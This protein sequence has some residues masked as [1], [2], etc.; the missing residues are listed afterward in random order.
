MRKD[1][2]IIQFLQFDECSIARTKN[3][4]NLVHTHTHTEREGGRIPVKIRYSQKLPGREIKQS[5]SLA[6]GNSERAPLFLFCLFLFSSSILQA[7]PSNHSLGTWPKMVS[8]PDITTTLFQYPPLLRTVS[9]SFNSNLLEQQ[10]PRLACYLHQLGQFLKIQISR[11]LPLR[12]QPKSLW[13]ESSN[14][15]IS[16]WADSVIAAGWLPLGQVTIQ[17]H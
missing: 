6:V 17:G 15:H 14:Q 3:P 13:R 12:T 7:T 2:D 10:L 16:S 9:V 11:V 8:S 1:S 5:Q 4:L